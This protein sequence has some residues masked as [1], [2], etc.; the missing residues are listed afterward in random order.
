[1]DIIATDLAGVVENIRISTVKRD[2]EGTSDTGYFALTGEITALQNWADV[3]R[4][5][6][7]AQLPAGTCWLKHCDCHR[8]YDTLN[9]TSSCLISP[10]TC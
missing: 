10:V 2:A 8:T 4:N 5:R 7:A 3:P 1:M 6:A 9:P